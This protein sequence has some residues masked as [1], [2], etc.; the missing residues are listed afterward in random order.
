MV[1]RSRRNRMKRDQELIDRIRSELN[2][3]KDEFSD[4]LIWEQTK[5]SFMAARISLGIK[6]EAFKKSI[7][8]LVRGIKDS[9]KKDKKRDGWFL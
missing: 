9:L 6:I 7:I 2:L 8:D 5:K 4:D 3:P 1:I